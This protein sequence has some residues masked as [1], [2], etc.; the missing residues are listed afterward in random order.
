MKRPCSAYENT[1][2]TA[3]LQTAEPSRAP[4]TQRSTTRSHSSSNDREVRYW[5]K[6]AERIFGYHAHEMLGSTLDPIIL[7]RLRQRH[8]EGFRSATACGSSRMATTT[9]SSFPPITPTGGMAARWLPHPSRLSRDER[10]A[11][12]DRASCLPETARSGRRDAG[13]GVH[14]QITGSLPIFSA[15]EV[16]TRLEADHLRSRVMVRP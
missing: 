1:A 11:R 4:S 14:A 8:T 12:P 13:G 3:A 15:V 2:F 9:S 10:R 5:N 7:E 16:R 6:G